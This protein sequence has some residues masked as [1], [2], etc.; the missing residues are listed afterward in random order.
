MSG[1]LRVQDLRARHG[2]GPEVVRGVD[3][4]ARRGEILALIGPN[5]AGKSTV[6]KAIMGLLPRSGSIELDGEDLVA[7]SPRDR[8]RRVSYVPQKSRLSARLTVRQVV[9]HG[10]F[11]HRSPIA[12]LSPV[13]HAVVER[14]LADV[15]AV[16]LAERP[17]PELSGGEQ[18]KVLLARALASE[19]PVLLLDEPTSA[20]DVRHGLE[21][22]ALLRRLAAR[23]AVVVVVLHDLSEVRA[24]ADRALLLEEGAVRRSGPVA[25]VVAPGPV[26]A[27][28]GVALVERGAL[29]FRLPV[30]EAG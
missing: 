5:G 27:V 28:Y 21:L 23:G 29:G 20:L 19:A 2:R 1:G 26:R 3:L 7:L 15:G 24:L 6:L 16:S 18:Q 12:R 14:A 30:E 25:Q 4:T 8:A 13:D 17:F 22:H 11:P 9:S 10:R